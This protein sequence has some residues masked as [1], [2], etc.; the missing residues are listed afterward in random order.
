MIEF[1][2]YIRHGCHLCEDM[3]AQLLALQDQATFAFTQQDVDA[4][5]Q[6]TQTYGHLVPVLTYG[7]E[8][9]CHYFLDQAAVLQAIGKQ[10]HP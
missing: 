9:L 4:D 2:L 5:P 6:L 8:T 10:P 3:Q 1:T 7:D